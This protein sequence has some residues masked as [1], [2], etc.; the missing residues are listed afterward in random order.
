V[1]AAR[2]VG[3]ATARWVAETAVQATRAAREMG[4]TA[5]VLTSFEI[6]GGDEATAVQRALGSHTNA[7]RAPTVRSQPLHRA[8]RPR[9][10]VTGG[11]RRVGGER[12]DVP[13]IPSKRVSDMGN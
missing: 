2:V 7:A 12:A 3:T 6:L 10:H 9:L 4:G 1:V 13:S 11:A 8:L 5:A